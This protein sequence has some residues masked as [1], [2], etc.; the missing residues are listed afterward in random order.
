MSENN[1][2]SID[3]KRK[4]DHVNSALTQQSDMNK[5]SY[6]AFDDLR[7]VH[8]SF[9]NTDFSEID[10]T[11]EWAGH[12]H[13]L[14]F[15]INGMTGGSDFTKKYNIALAQVAHETG[16]TMASGSNSIAMKDTSVSDSFTVIRQHNP[17]GFVLA[18]LGAH[19]NLEN[20]K[21]AVDLLQAN[22]L[23]IHLN[24][25]Q[26][27]VMPEGDRDFSMWEENISQIVESVGV[28]VVIKEVGFGMSRKTIQRLLNLGVKT[29]D[30]SGRGGTNFVNIEND[31]R[32]QIDFSALGLW[33]Q[34]TPESLLES[35][36]YQDSI[37]VLASGGIRHFYDIVK[38]LALGARA[39]GISGKFLQSVHSKG[40]DE[41]VKMV[42]QWA[43]AIKHIMLLVDA[44]NISALAETQLV[45]TAG[46]REWAE[47]RNINYKA[48]ANR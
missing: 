16:L 8:H 38:A 32:D 34:T 37:E 25:P 42:H 27:V 2:I 4:N 13:S 15:Y 41:T 18:N 39:T 48:L 40:V 12:T 9:S 45:V 29:I 35:H 3:Q 30:V 33:G 26:E 36:S 28:P 23:Q 6:S 5:R 21:K 20:A 1:N 22:A 19:H 43:E 11:T 46:L 47:T 31:R 17:N 10:L 24:V 7:F 44:P 14:P